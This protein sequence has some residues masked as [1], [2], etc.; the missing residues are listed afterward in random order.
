MA[1]VVDSK[2]TE[3]LKL[4]KGLQDSVVLDYNIPK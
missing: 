4:Q 3:H 1:L 2:Y